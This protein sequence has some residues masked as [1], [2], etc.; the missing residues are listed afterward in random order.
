MLFRKIVRVGSLGKNYSTFRPSMQLAQ[1]PNSLTGYA[2]QPLHRLRDLLNRASV[3][4]SVDRQ[5]ENAKK[6]S[7]GAECSLT[8]QVDR[9]YSGSGKKGADSPHQD[10]AGEIRSLTGRVHRIG[11]SGVWTALVESCGLD[12]NGTEGG[13]TAYHRLTER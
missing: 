2:D 11:E 3:Q 7:H 4:V 6:L 5:P 13:Q 8:V 9:F 10:G 12:P 1:E